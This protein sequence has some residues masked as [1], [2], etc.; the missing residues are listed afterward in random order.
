MC[1]RVKYL[2]SVGW[3]CLVDSIG[4]LYGIVHGA[5]NTMLMR[6]G[7]CAAELRL[8]GLGVVSSIEVG[9]VCDVCSFCVCCFRFLGLVFRC[10]VFLNLR[11]YVLVG[12]GVA[13]VSWFGGSLFVFLVVH[14][15]STLVVVVGIMGGS[16]F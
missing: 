9:F 6:D 8:M 13:G 3:F 5:G 1:L 14:A 2:S 12:V 15:C 16:V 10:R 11:L 7:A 4:G